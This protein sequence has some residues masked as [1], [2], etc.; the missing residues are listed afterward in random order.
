MAEPAYVRIAGEYARRIRA[1]ELTPGAQLPS[2]PELAERHGVSQI[3]IRKAVELLLG[4][5]LVR[6]QPR[7]GVFVADRPNLTR[8][9]P[10]RQ[11]ESPES[12]FENEAVEPVEIRRDTR[13]IEADAEL[14][15]DLGVEVGSKVVHVI[16]RASEG[17]RPI[18]VSD[19]YQTADVPDITT[20]VFLEE[21][22]TDALP[23]A[24]HAEWL[25]TPAG[26]LVK[27]VYQ[28]Y[29]GPGEKVLMIS[30]V[31]Y[32]R[33]RYD[34]FLFRMAL[35]PGAVQAGSSTS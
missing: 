11:F 26:E 15:E 3:V 4:Q 27:S 12:T 34:A 28:R 18:S 2:Y 9:S 7:R 25:R 33:N 20:A 35:A 29:L 1:G 14:A 22:V 19:S 8:V 21:T 30:S 13:T 6:T 31:S 10:E 17:G 24:S 32:P 23:V 5:G 16:T